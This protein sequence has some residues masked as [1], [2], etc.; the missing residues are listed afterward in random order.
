MCDKF[1]K[2]ETGEYPRSLTVTHALGNVEDLG[3]RGRPVA[4]D[5]ESGDSLR[6]RSGDRSAVLD[7]FGPGAMKDAKLTELA[8][9]LSDDTP[10]KSRADLPVQVPVTALKPGFSPR[11]DGE[12]TKH[13]RA[14]AASG[15]DMAPLV[16]HR[17]SMR[18]IDGMHRL[19]AATLRGLDRVLVRF[20]DGSADD[21]FVLAVQL[22]SRHGLPLS[23]ADRRAA[24]NRILRSHPHWSDQAVATVTGTSDK[25]VAALRRRST[26]ELRAGPL[27]TWPPPPT[28]WCAATRP[29]SPTT[30]ARGPVRPPN[31]SARSTTGGC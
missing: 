7:R 15:V 23:P 4:A 2:S 31:G 29:R 10:G 6:I 11:V 28:R 30:R 1:R 21:A 12:N 22:N 27:G 9:K 8:T 18:V 25:T 5:I 14:L 13:A 26:S 20:F 19:Q 24:A 17:S 3:Q 16:V